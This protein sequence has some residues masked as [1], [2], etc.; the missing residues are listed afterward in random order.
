MQARKQRFC[1]TIVYRGREEGKE[2]EGG[3]KGEKG[4]EEVRWQES[5]SNSYDV[6]SHYLA[7]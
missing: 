4:R 5:Y 6:D 2:R 7:M 1:D 3:K